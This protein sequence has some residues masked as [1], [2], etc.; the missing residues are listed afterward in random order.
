MNNDQESDPNGPTFEESLDC[1]N[2]WQISHGSASRKRRPLCT[3]A[4]GGQSLCRKPTWRRCQT[5]ISPG[6]AA[7][8][9]AIIAPKSASAPTADVGRCSHRS[10]I[11]NHCRPRRAVSACP[12]G[13]RGR[14]APHRRLR[15]C[16]SA[17]LAGPQSRR[18][19]PWAL[20]NGRMCCFIL[21][22]FLLREA[23]DIAAGRCHTY[24][25]VSAV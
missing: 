22:S 15:T 1:G 14:P 13:H 4:A 20:D 23:G 9:R 17:A 12:V 24:L 3:R 2:S 8:H 25:T 7:C 21:S 18:L 5:R 19:S 10:G 11:V 16:A 6:R